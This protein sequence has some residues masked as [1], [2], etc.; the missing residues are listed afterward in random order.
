ISSE[1][2]SASVNRLRSGLALAVGATACGGASTNSVSD[3]LIA[4]FG[5]ALPQ[6]LEI[7]FEDIQHIVLIAPGL[8]RGMRGDEGIGQVPQRRLGRQ[9]FLHRN[10]DGGAR[11]ATGTHRRH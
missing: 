4:Q 5:L 2:S 6:A 3:N 10:I 7:F 9:W 8:A 11:N 1:N